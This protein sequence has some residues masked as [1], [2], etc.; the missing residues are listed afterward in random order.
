[1][2]KPFL[3]LGLSCL[4]VLSCSAPKEQIPPLENMQQTSQKIIVY[5][6]MTRLFGN[7]VTTNKTY[8]T[9]EEN[10]VGKFA[11]V[12]STALNAIKQLGV[13]HVWYTGLHTAWNSA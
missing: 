11:D 1:M 5:Q 12:N 9:L 3:Y 13:T 4:I 10:G 7:K 2:K 8:G 6:M